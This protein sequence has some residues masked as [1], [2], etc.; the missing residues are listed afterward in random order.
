MSGMPRAFPLSPISPAA[1]PRT[2]RSTCLYSSGRESLIFWSFRIGGFGPFPAGAPLIAFF[3]MSGMPRAFP[4]SP[5]SPV[6]HPHTP[7]PTCLY[8]SGRESLISWSFRI[9]GFGPYPAGA[10]LIAFFAMSGMPRAFQLSP[11]SP[12][13]HPHT[14][15]STCLYSSGRESLIFWSFRI[16]GFGPYP[17]VAFRP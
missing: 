15:R 5:I 10:P 2:P 1:H 12:V 11:I 14:P 6:A 3:A 7:R 8:S 9:G 13:A 17:A 4:L 16:G